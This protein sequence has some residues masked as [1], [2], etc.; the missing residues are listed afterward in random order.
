MLEI[1]TGILLGILLLNV[2]SVILF[3]Y[4]SRILESE[5]KLLKEIWGLQRKNAQKA[6]TRQEKPQTKPIEAVAPKEI[7]KPIVGTEYVPK[8]P[9]SMRSGQEK[10]IDEILAEF[11]P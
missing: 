6:Q 9:D 7:Q 3:F 2:V 5:E 10:L 1:K 8:K 4:V 11:L